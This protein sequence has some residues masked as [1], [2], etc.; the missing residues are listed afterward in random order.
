MGRG[1]KY[2]TKKY[3]MGKYKISNNIRKSCQGCYIGSQIDVEFDHK[4]W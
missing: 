1:G 4:M 3:K 2:E